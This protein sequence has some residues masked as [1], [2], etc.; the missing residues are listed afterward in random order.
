M[1]SINNAIVNRIND[2]KQTDEMTLLV[3]SV[4]QLSVVS[5]QNESNEMINPIEMRRQ[6]K[7]YDYQN[8]LPIAR[9]PCDRRASNTS[10][11][12]QYVHF[13]HTFCFK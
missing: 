13:S 10:L 4:Q 6:R 8:D 7:S 2:E 12:L 1:D 5:M 9:M 11:L 3:P